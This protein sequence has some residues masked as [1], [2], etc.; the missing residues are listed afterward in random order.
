V[1]A[2]TLLEVV[3]D[4]L[5]DLHTTGITKLLPRLINALQASMTVTSDLSQKKIGELREEIRLASSKSRFNA[6]PPSKYVLLKRLGVDRLLGNNLMREIDDS[7]FG[8]E[9]TPILAIS[10]LKELQHLLSDLRS[11]TGKLLSG[12]KYFDIESDKLD[13]GSFEVIIGIPGRAIHDELEPLAREAMRVNRILGVFSEIATGSRDSVKLRAVASSDPTFYLIT[14]PAVAALFVTVIERVVALYEKVLTIIKLQRDLKAQ[15]IPSDITSAL[16]GHIDQIVG[17][18][19]D[20]IGKQIEESHLRAM[21][22]GRRS[23]LI[24]EFRHT[25]T[26]IAKRIDD[27]YLFDVRGEPL[28]APADDEGEASQSARTITEALRKV[29]ELR[30]KLQHFEAEREPILR[31]SGS[32]E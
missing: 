25:L 7:M 18:G 15:E 17:K 22:E 30:P 20:D 13:P 23:E 3:A 19:L 8:Q 32:D 29:E 9:I 6:Y 27:G 31:L 1:R 5:A 21:E 2:E 24:I 14:A 12:A 28:A 4:I 10:K 11:E 16:K 26:D